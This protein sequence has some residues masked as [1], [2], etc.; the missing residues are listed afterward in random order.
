MSPTLQRAALDQHG[1]DGAAAAIELGLDHDAFGR[2]VGIG[3]EV[4]DFGLQ[5]DGLL[6]LV[7]AGLS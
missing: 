2:T 3:L 4:E 7:E 6:E 5:Q 1:R